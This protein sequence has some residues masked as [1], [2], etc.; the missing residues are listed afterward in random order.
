MSILES[1]FHGKYRSPQ[2]NINMPPELRR[3]RKE[4]LNRIEAALGADFLEE[5]WDN[6]CEIEQAQNLHFFREGFRLG[7]MMIRELSGPPD[8]PP[9]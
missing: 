3:K 9:E 7:A 1:L 4:L 5:Y 2:E 6:F 8:R